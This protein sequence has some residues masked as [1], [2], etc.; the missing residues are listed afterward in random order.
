MKN[1]FKVG[2][3]VT[4]TGYV[5]GVTNADMK[6]G[7]VTEVGKHTIRVKVLDHKYEHYNGKCYSVCPSLFKKVEDKHDWKL[8]IIPDGD[9]TKGMYYK[10]GKFVEKV[11]CRKHPDDEY[12]EK[13]ACETLIN[14]LFGE[15][16][17][18]SAESEFKA[19]DFVEVIGGRHNGFRGYVVGET[20]SAVLVDFKMV[21]PWSHRGLL[22]ELPYETGSYVWKWQLKK[23]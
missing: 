11:T 17:K 8:V 15:D 12:S 13:V 7:L 21:Y 16:E 4:G 20:N 1:K 10:D 22:N 18:E 5:Y 2:D 19:G 6:R 3:I 9:G 23:V 14:R